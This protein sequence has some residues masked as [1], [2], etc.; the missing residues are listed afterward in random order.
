MPIFRCVCLSCLG[1]IP[2]SAAPTRHENF[3][4]TGSKKVAL[5]FFANERLKIVKTQVS[6]RLRR[7][8]LLEIEPLFIGNA[9]AAARDRTQPGKVG[10]C[11]AAF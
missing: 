5:P 8:I 7:E 4:W 3:G 9:S 1:S 2:G 10:A 11:G 6:E